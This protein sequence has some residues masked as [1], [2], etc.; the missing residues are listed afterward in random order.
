MEV[1]PH[2]VL[3]PEM[4]A[5]AARV[6]DIIGMKRHVTG[7]PQLSEPVILVGNHISYLD[8]AFL[9]SVL[10]IVFIT[11][12][13]IG[14]WP[15][16]GTACRVVG[17]V[18]VDRDSAESR[19]K[20]S[21]AVIPCLRERRQSIGVFPSGTTTMDESKPW[22]WGIFQI[23]KQNNVPIQPFRLRYAPLR[24]AAF[25]MEDSFV[26]HLWT[27]LSQGG[28]DAF[29]EFHEPVMVTDPEKDAQRWWEW[30]RAPLL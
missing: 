3:H 21:D 9:M 15:L 17:T 24:R 12:K 2:E 18:F 11:K 20:A 25:L 19:K 4:K 1:A 23:A 16:F 13:Q 5:W 8:I 10:P 14:S 7:V 26:P 6:L 30:S 22:R 29:I 27:L 28:C